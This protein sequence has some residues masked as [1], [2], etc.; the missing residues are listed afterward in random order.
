MKDLIRKL[1]VEDNKTCFEIAEMLQLNQDEIIKQIKSMSINKVIKTRKYELIRASALTK[2]QKQFIFGCLIGNAQLKKRSK[3]TP[4]YLTVRDNNKD[5]ILWKKIHLAKFVNVIM[6]KNHKNGCY[7]QFDTCCHN[8]LNTIHHIMYDNNKKVI[9]EQ[10]GNYLGVISLSAMIND[11]AV[12]QPHQTIKLQTHKY[13]Q[14]EQ[15]ILK[16]ILKIN[17]GI[18][19]KICTYVR[20][21]INYYYMSLNKRNTKILFDMINPILNIG[22]SSTTKC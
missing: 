13:S 9:T 15:E 17:F 21:N 6:T 16:R 19:S 22:K 5:N 1:F 20:N 2:E 12:I 18:N 3:K 8:E 4:Y 11:L 7:Y 10:L 14:Q